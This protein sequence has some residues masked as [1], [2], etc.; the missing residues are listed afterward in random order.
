MLELLAVA[1]LGVRLGAQPEAPPAVPLADLIAK[2]EAYLRSQQDS[3]S[4]GWAVAPAGANFPAITGLVVNG[5]LLEPRAADDAD[6]AEG[7][8]YILTFLRPDGGIYDKLLPSYNTAI[9]LSALARS[10]S[11]AAKAAIKPAQ[12][13]LRGLQYSEASVVFEGLDEAPTPVG[14]EHPFFGGVGYGRHGR[15]DLSNLSFMLQGLHDSGVPADDAAFQRAVVFLQRTQM[16]E[17]APSGT[18]V[19]DMAYAKGST[20]GGFIYATSVNKDQVATGQSFAGEIEE[21]LSDGTQASRLRAYGS[22]TYAGFKSYAYAGLHKDDPRVLAAWGWIRRNYTLQ[23]NPGLGTDGMY[24][25]YLT[26]ARAL[27]ASGADTI[28]TIRPDGTGEARDWRRDL[29]A[30]L[31]ALQEPDG[32]FRVVDER[33]MEDNPVLITAYALI[34]LKHAAE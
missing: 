27:D 18:P 33:W 32:S 16:L 34:A 10:D 21:T 19:N 26:F 2:A 4:G 25:Y 3:A 13:F 8:A 28:E 29:T 5:L 6:A 11:P 24:Y 20:Q 14:R 9:C 12:D 17:R 7:V 1:A 15:P 23:E 30:R 31:A 22:M